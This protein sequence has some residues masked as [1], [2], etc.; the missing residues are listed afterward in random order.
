MA[1]PFFKGKIHEKLIWFDCFQM[2][3]DGS[4]EN[5]K[6]EEKPSGGEEK[7]YDWGNEHFCL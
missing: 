6:A 7:L 4:C 2:Q 5:E 3:E 1:F